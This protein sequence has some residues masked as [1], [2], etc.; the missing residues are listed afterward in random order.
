[1]NIYAKSSVEEFRIYFI[2]RQ[3]EVER[4]LKK[5]S[6]KSRDVV[7]AMDDYI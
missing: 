1:V 5:S 4:F 2:G 6:G 3:V 7:R